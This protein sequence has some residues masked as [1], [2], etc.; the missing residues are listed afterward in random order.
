MVI[1][2]FNK[3]PLE[4]LCNQ[5]YLRC[6]IVFCTRGDAV[7]NQIITDIDNYAAPEALTPLIGNEDDHC[8]V[9]MKSVSVKRCQYNRIRWRNTTPASR[10]Q[11]LLDLAK[12]DWA[13]V[14]AAGSADT[15]TESFHE[16]VTNILDRHCPYSH[17]I[18]YFVPTG[19][20]L[21]TSY[22][23]CLFN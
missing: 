3:M 14:S 21:Q 18:P 8:A 1:G 6:C 4:F 15:K 13:K 22:F 16:T 17:I 12:Q 5:S 2:N 7:L 11:V 20:I 23:S 10:Q 19:Y 9:Y